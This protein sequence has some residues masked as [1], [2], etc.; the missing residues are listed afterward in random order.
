M[1]EKGKARGARARGGRPKKTGPVAILIGVACFAAVLAGFYLLSGDGAEPEGAPSVRKG[2]PPLVPAPAAPTPSAATLT[3][4]A[5][6]KIPAPPPVEENDLFAAL[7]YGGHRAGI[8]AAERTGPTKIT[9]VYGPGLGTWKF[10]KNFYVF[11]VVSPTDEDFQRGVG[12]EHV[13]IV[14]TEPDAEYPPGWGGSRCKRY[15]LEVSL[16]EGRPMKE[17]HRYWIRVNAH[18]VGGLMKRAKWIVERGA[19]PPEDLE[20]RYGIRE[21]YILSPQALHLVTGSGLDTDRLKEKGAIVVTCPEDPEF[22]DGVSPSAVSRRSNLDFYVPAG[23]PWDF[24]QRHEL[25]LIFD[26]RFKNGK[27]YTVD[28]NGKLGSPLTVGVSRAALELDD[29]KTINLAI[30]VNQ[31]G[32]LPDTKE[33]YGYLG[34]WMGEMNA[35]DFGPEA[36]SFVVRD[37][38]THEAVFEGEPTLRRKATYKLVEGKLTPDAEAVKGP[39]TVY[40]QDLSYEDV[41]QIDLSPLTDEGVYYVAVPGMGRSFA[42]RIA[43]DI[44]VEPWKITMSGCFHQRCGIELK[45]P[46]TEHYRP[47]C[48][49]NKTEYATMRGGGLD[50]NAWKELP[51]HATDGTKRDLWG[52]HHD[53]GD[54]N[55]RSHLDVAEHFFL[56][57]EM[58]GGAFADGQLNIP[59]NGPENK[60][61]L[62]D[63]LDEAYWALDLW[64]RLQ[65]AD[66][67]VH[68]GIESNGDPLTGDAAAGD[69]LREF[70]FAK[71]SIASYRFAAV[72]AHGSILWKKHGRKEKAGELLARAL[73]AW[74][75]AQRNPEKEEKHRQKESD[76]L[77]FAAALLF[78]VTGDGKY[79]AAFK[80]HSIIANDPSAPPYLWQKHDQGYGSYYYAMLEEADPDVRSKIVASFEREFNQWARWAA[81]TSYRYMRSPYSPNNWGTGGRPQW[82]FRPAMT[83]HLTRDPEIRAKARQWITLTCDF[84]LGCHPLNLV[85][86]VGLGQ[87]Y[88]TTAFHHLQ[89]NSPEGIIPGLQCNAAGAHWRMAGERPPSGGMGKWPAM[90]MYP[91]GQWPDLYFYSENASPGMNEG[92]RATETAFA[93]GLLMPPAEK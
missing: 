56:L 3:P 12:A 85:F 80:Q 40:K 8:R 72:A 36:L 21:I 42:F 37:A 29:R 74:D 39:E 67:G 24:R 11:Q 41:Y 15:T 73:R 18:G 1:T 64:T 52:G 20:P 93:Y 47:A 22:R 50:S 91:P 76:Q 44:Y 75:W 70:A 53:A 78:R 81:T 51:K 49:R 63:V 30:K 69:R 38:R 46:W 35:Y 4:P 88:V 79:D 77:V 82:L 13:V 71:D 32:Y 45:E 16:P 28:I 61:G 26:L 9:V 55:P 25:F 68:H 23:W 19:T 17:G 60:N 87:R 43:R 90:S 6:D 62:P 86:T 83:M 2:P 59:E 57:Y 27:T 7:P 33:K 54:W 89:L 14:G 84:S 92:A 5:A 58:N 31:Y 48:H 10:E 34:M 66:G 65:D